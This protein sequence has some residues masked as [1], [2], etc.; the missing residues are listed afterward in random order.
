VKLINVFGL[1]LPATIIIF[2]LSYIVGDILTEVYGS[3][4]LVASSTAT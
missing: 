3:I 2:P 4:D 1:V